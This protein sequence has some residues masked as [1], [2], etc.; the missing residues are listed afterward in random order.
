MPDPAESHALSSTF[1]M[2]D[3]VEATNDA[4]RRTRTVTIVLVVAS[5]LIGIGWYNSMRWSW[6]LHRIRQAYDPDDRFVNRMLDSDR[7][8]GVLIADKDGKTP[9]DRFRTELQQATVKAYVENVRFLR[10]PF[11]GVAFDVNDLGV[12]GG[13]ALIMILLAMRYSLSREIKNLNVS[14]RE[15]IY[16]N[17]LSA[18]YHA[19]AMRQVFTVPHMKGEKKNLWLASS[20]RLICILPAGVFLLGVIYDYYSTFRLGVYSVKVVTLALIVETIWLALIIYL[21]FRCWER[22]RHIDEVWQ[23]HWDRMIGHKSAVI[24]LDKDLIQEFGSDAEVNR[25]LR[26]LRERPET[27]ASRA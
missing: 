13:I 14:L 7:H 5:V 6:E 23:R 2:K 16:H 8:P 24:R 11:F 25:A 12:I 17:D 27:S 22:K 10:A 21:A 3:Y 15:A 20:S 1:D 4:A 26:S 9:A 18:F 19:L